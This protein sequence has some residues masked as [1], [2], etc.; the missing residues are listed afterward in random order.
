MSTP[1]KAARHAR[2]WTLREAVTQLR[3]AAAELGETLPHFESVRHRLYAYESGQAQPG[4]FYRDLLCRVY[5]TT[6]AAMGWTPHRTEQPGHGGYHHGRT[7][8]WTETRDVDAITALLYAVPL[9]TARLRQQSRTRLWVYLR[10]VTDQPGCPERHELAGGVRRAR[11]L[12]PAWLDTD[13]LAACHQ[14]ARLVLGPRAGVRDQT[15]DQVPGWLTTARLAAA[16][17]AAGVFTSQAPP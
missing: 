4:P 2:G 9:D 6:P 1:V 11:A 8:P 5:D 3:A 10:L 15:R 16:S 17:T 7:P 14:L 13:R 12:L